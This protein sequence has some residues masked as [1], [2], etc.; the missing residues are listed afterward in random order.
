[1]A[2]DAILSTVG[3][4]KGFPVATYDLAGSE[5]YAES[6]STENVTVGGP[7]RLTDARRR[8]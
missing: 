6:S 4:A 5:R 3:A 2:I 1:M 7:K 8:M